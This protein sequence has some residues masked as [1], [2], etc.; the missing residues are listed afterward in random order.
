VGRWPLAFQAHSARGLF[1]RGLMASSG[2][3]LHV[4]LWPPPGSV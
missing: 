4:D 2:P 3:R 1:V